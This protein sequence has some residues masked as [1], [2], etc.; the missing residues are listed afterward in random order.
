LVD[1]VAATKAAYAGWSTDQKEEACWALG[2]I[3][4]GPVAWDIVEMHNADWIYQ[5]YRPACATT[6]GSPACGQTV[7]VGSGCHFHGSPNYV[8]FG[9]MANLCGMWRTTVSAL[10]WA[11]KSSA[12]NYEGSKAWALAGYDGWPSVADPAGDRNNCTPACPT[13]YSD[14]PF[15]LFWYPTAPTETVTSECETALQ[16]HR[17]LRDNPRALD[18]DVGF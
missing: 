5:N 13:P 14:G 7:Q 16:N 17:F 3:A 2:N 8:I 6:G 15:T 4:C 18:P 11:Y 12:G 9:V 10:V 1:V